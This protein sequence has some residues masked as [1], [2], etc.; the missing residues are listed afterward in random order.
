MGRVTALVWVGSRPGL[1]G[2]SS[3]ASGAGTEEVAHV[4]DLE[5]P[6]PLLGCGTVSGHVTRNSELHLV[7][8]GPGGGYCL[9]SCVTVWCGKPSAP[10]VSVSCES[11][12]RAE[13][14]RLFSVPTPGKEKCVCVS[15][16]LRRKLWFCLDYP[17]KA[18]DLGDR[19]RSQMIKSQRKLAKYFQRYSVLM[20]PYDD[21]LSP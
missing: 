3:L 18:I 7:S 16:G 11:P 14:E 20:S 21:L 6:W 2:L 17:I 1:L 12:L 13:A 19:R 15:L 8:N 9:K 10:S 5:E 4:P